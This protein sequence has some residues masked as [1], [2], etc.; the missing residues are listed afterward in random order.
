MFRVAKTWSA[1]ASPSRMVIAYWPERRAAK[2]TRRPLTLI[3]AVEETWIGGVVPSFS[4][5][6]IVWVA[7][8]TERILP[9][10]IR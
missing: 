6:V 8:E 1:G 3:R 7:A 9:T 10:S 5:S 2:P 4:L